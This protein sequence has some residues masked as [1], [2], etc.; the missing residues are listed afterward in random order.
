MG[1]SPQRT[2]TR[3]S[4]HTSTRTSTQAQIGQ[5]LADE[6]SLGTSIDLLD[7]A[8]VLADRMQPL[9]APKDRHSIVDG[10]IADLTGLGPLQRFMD[11]PGISEVMVTGPCR[12]WTESGG[13]MTLH[14]VPE[15]TESVIMRLVERIIAPLGLVL[16]RASPT[17][18]ARL[19][20]GSRLNAI[21]S[22]LA[23]DGP[24][25]TIRRF[26]SGR[27]LLTDFA[28][29]QQADQL[30]S[31]VRDHTNIVVSGGT[32]SGK[33]SL[34]NTLS[35]HINSDERVVTIEDAAELQL[36]GNHVVRLEARPGALDGTG[37]VSIRDLVRNAL[38]MRP[39]RLVIGEVR[40]GEAFD[41]VQA[42]NTGHAG[43]MTTVHAN[44]ALDAVRRLEVMVLMAGFD[45]PLVAIR[46]QLR[47]AIGVVVHVNRCGSKRRV[48]QV[49]S[50]T[51]LFAS[52]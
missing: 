21:I 37:R 11:E 16:N 51:D 41:M 42:L 26:T 24:V 33:T 32:G 27:F 46:E 48:E 38:R 10:V 52:L 1:G 9:L 8:G 3:T 2:S 23:I 12:V 20:D 29:P 14:H 4:T 13:Q 22:P 47:S 18:D 39:D 50:A 28:E 30:S 15:L 19:G 5:L 36:P 7:R 43:S 45:I 44:T 31:L 25:V 6:L 49:V 35:A 34:L 17:V 40:G